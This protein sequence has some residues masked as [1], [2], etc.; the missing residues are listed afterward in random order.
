MEFGFGVPTRGPLATPDNLAALARG[1][2]EMGFEI[3]SVSDH[4]VIPRSIES[5]YPYNET[6]EFAGG[7][8]G[9]C[10]EQ[11]TMLSFLA[12][13]TSK[14][15]LLTSVMV[16]PHRSPVLAAKMIATVDVL[17][18][19]RV[20]LG[21]GVGWMREEFEAIGAPPYDER[22]AVGDEYIRVFKEL[23][24][25]EEPSY[26]GDYAAFADVSFQPK[27][28]Q[29]P[30]PPIWIGGESPPALRRAGQL[31]NAWYPIGSNPRF[32][33]GTIEQLTGYMS[34]V[35]NYA[36]DVGRDP[37]EIDFAYS[38]SWYDD[39]EA[40]TGPDGS[41]RVFTGT[42]EQI[43]GDVRAFEELGVRHLMVGLQADSVDESL[44]RMD[45]FA[46]SV[47]PLV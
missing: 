37:A 5:R 40:Q 33:V 16:L 3:V 30:H 43:A 28:V 2:E 45:R 18:A 10:L 15:R 25:S 7:P 13:V 29:K 42:P 46:D 6:G 20:I 11:L 44:G 38:A 21:C 41:R 1:G 26:E 14:A 34:R 39:R 4:I 31:G 36:R 24:T 22:G 27:P 23:W 47:R 17:S 9:E 8:T 32:R 35:R 12:G 19:G